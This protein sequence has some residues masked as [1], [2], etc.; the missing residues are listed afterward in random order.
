MA[1]KR[2]HF[3]YDTHTRGF[4]VDSDEARLWPAGSLIDYVLASDYDTL[5]ADMAEMKSQ[6]R[7]WQCASAASSDRIRELEAALYGAAESLATFRPPHDADNMP[8]WTELDEVTLHDA[9]RLCGKYPTSDRPGV[10]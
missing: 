5:A 2:L 6:A 8:R 7:H 9:Q 10:K 4:W 3:K 1:N